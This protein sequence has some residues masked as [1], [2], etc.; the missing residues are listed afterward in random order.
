MPGVTAYPP[1]PKDVPTYPL[2]VVDF[3]LIQAGDVDEINRLFDAATTIGF[4]YLK[5][6]GIGEEVDPMFDMGRET[7][8]LPLDEKLKYE[9]GDQG[10]SFGYKKAG[11]NIMD[12]QGTRD[13][14]EFVNVSRDDALAW[15]ASVHRTYPS[16]INVRMESTVRPFVQKA[17]AINNTLIDVL[18]DK[19]GLP[20]GTL[21][22]FHKVEEHSGC[23]A[24]VIRAPPVVG[25]PEK[26]FLT[27]HT[28]Y[29]SLSLL[30]NRLGG[31][32][33][34]P[35]DTDQWYYV[36]PIPG[37]AICNIGDA[38]NIFSGGILRSNIHRVI[39]PPKEQA[40]YERWSLVF[41][42][43][44]N[45]AV[46]LVAQSD[47]SPR[48]AESVARAP[49][50]KYRPG[51]TAKEWIARRFMTQR[52]T[53]YKGMESWN[54]HMGTEDTPIPGHPVKLAKV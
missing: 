33:V 3:Q 23:I 39:P 52:A 19:L 8:A 26:L 22:A 29:G 28:D 40:Q 49:A 2:V 43:R 6:H 53:N 36:Q 10:S 24:R 35:P 12:S 30:F 54:A 1:F 42:T 38:L 11:A 7:I 21:A 14:T 50:G 45:D 16:T 41:F 25:V 48:I 15:P 5:N 47:K 37:L 31:L 32:Q 9:M 44:P 51:V 17:V 20:K 34:L 13:V 4:W 18:N 46:E 27:A